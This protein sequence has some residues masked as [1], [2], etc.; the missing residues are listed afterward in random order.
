MIELI[1]LEIIVKY[2]QKTSEVKQKV[3]ELGFPRPKIACKD[4]AVDQ[5]R[6][7]FLTIFR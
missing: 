5:T 7:R 2:H 1:V 4:F 3:V 6:D